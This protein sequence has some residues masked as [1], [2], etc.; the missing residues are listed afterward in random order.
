MVAIDSMLSAVVQPGILLHTVIQAHKVRF[1]A[2]SPFKIL[3]ICAVS[4]VDNE[5]MVSG[6]ESQAK[7]IPGF[8]GNPE[9]PVGSLRRRADTGREENFVFP[10][11]V[12]AL[13][14]SLANES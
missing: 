9:K 3:P 12:L 1:R 7:D 10:L 11:S 8:C 13:C 4:H 2:R 6:G 5:I 14:V